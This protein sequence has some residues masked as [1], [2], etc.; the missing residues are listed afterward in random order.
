MIDEKKHEAAFERAA[1]AIYENYYGAGSWKAAGT[2]E[3][4]HA[5]QSVRL[6]ISAFEKNGLLFSA[7]SDASPKPGA[8]STPRAPVPRRF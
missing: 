3:R 7:T 8:A 5:R 6:A 2:P 4:S 1:R